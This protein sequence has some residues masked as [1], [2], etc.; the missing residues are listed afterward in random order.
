MTENAEITDSHGWTEDAYKK[1]PSRLNSIVFF[2]TCFIPIFASLIFGAVSTGTLAILTFLTGVLLFF[3]FIDSWKN[4]RVTLS[5]DSL[6][7]PIIGL[8]LIG[9][10]QLIPI[11]SYNF[12]SELLSIPATGALS[13]D[14]NSTKLA[15]VK[16]CIFLVIFA[17]TLS[18]LNSG[19]R[20]KIVVFTVIIFAAVM[21]FI[22]I[23]QNL[24][25]PSFI[26]GLR[27]VDYANPF[28]SY[29]NRHHFAAFMEMTIGL[30]LALLVG[31]G[32]A[33]DKRLLL[34]I[35]ILLMGIA[36]IFTSSRG[37]FLSLIGV[38]GFIVLINTLVKGKTVK[39]G[40]SKTG[41]TKNSLSLIGGSL[42]L[43]AVLI[44][45]VIWLGGD[46]SVTRGVGLQ[47]GGDDFSNGRIHFWSTSLQ[48]IRDNPVFGTGLESFGVAFTKYDTWNGTAR[49][50][51]AHNDYLQTL[52]DSGIIGFIC[53]A[54][55]VFLLFRKSFRL[56]K[57]TP[58][59]FR[60]H[61]A[62]GALA[63]CFGIL[64]HSFVDFPL[65]TNANMLFF[66]ILVALATVPIKYPKLYRKP[67]LV[68][69]E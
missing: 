22:G 4:K 53:I 54:F 58:N 7:L 35:A 18:N 5:T 28:A 65:R 37:G 31:R 59:I 62:I 33:K 56:I 6:Q 8:I 38:I 60:R 25:S 39:E 46:D 50:E 19:K 51:Q 14:P 24:A 10:I 9:L 32:I 57:S 20:L 13:L 49:V 16:L 55:F 26:Y 69:S 64:I 23:L 1:K 61:V 3:W 29:V 42:G 21:A 68:R 17:I 15:V 40:D 30:T 27:E 11:W 66:L 12:S 48:I 34:V 2:L 63:G 67:T 52:T 47:S 41:I 45:A 43:V 36:I 44:V